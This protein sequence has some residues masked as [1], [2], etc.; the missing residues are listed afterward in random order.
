[1]K[2]MSAFL[3]LLMANEAE[4]FLVV[5]SRT[6]Q[7]VQL[8]GFRQSYQ[9]NLEQLSRTGKI[10]VNGKVLDMNGASQMIEKDLQASKE[11]AQEAEARLIGLKTE[12]NAKETEQAWMIEALDAEME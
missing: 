4:A 2:A 9:Y 1:M 12:M 11:E 10:E 7:G 8:F 3:A 5:P 6:Q